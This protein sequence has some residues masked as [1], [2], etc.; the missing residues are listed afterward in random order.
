VVFTSLMDDSA[1]GDSNSDAAGTTPAPGD[2]QGIQIAGSQDSLLEDVSIRFASQALAITADAAVVVRGSILNSTHAIRACNW[3]TS[4][5]VDATHVDWGSADGPFG[6]PEELVCGAVSVSPWIGQAEPLGLLYRVPNCD[7]SST[8]DVVLQTAA[9]G[10]YANLSSWQTICGY[11]SAACEHVERIRACYSAA[12]ELAKAGSTFPI[13]E[14]SEDTAEQV[15]V[16]FVEAASIYLRDEGSWVGRTVGAV[17]QHV[18]RIL[19]V[20]D[21]AAALTHAYNSCR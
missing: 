11:D 19:Q 20:A 9:D 6:G 2:W 3:T 18:G 4:C 7:Q 13:P 16:T 12:L 14:S 10:Y 17:G 8:P 15:G 21:I 1:G 5:G